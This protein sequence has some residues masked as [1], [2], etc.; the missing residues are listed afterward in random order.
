MKLV[1]NYAEWK[2][3]V[4]SILDQLYAVERYLNE[5]GKERKDVMMTLLDFANYCDSAAELLEWIES[6]EGMDQYDDQRLSSY[7]ARSPIR[8]LKNI[9][10]SEKKTQGG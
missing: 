2:A 4:Q 8:R 5:A 1:E 9:A 6:R 3:A 10:E 7:H